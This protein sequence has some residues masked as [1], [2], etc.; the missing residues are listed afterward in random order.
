MVTIHEFIRRF[1][2]SRGISLQSMTN[3][4]G[5]RSKTSIDRIL[6]GNAGSDALSVFQTRLEATFSMTD[7]ERD[8]LA[9]V[10][11]MTVFKKDRAVVRFRNGTEIE[12]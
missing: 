10:E 8:E 7:E 11:R 1:A 5:Y 2:L 6:S 9:F 12:V 4:L 3:M